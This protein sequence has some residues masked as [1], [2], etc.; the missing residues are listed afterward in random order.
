MPDYYDVTRLDVTAII[1]DVP[2]VWSELPHLTWED[3]NRRRV[4][5]KGYINAPVG[6]ARFALHPDYTLPDGWRLR[7]NGNLLYNP[8]L[9]QTVELRF[10]ATRGSESAYS[11]VLRITRHQAFVS[12][13][14]PDRINIGLEFNNATQRVYVYNTTT[15][16]T[17]D[18]VGHVQDFVTFFDI[19]GNEQVSESLELSLNIPLRASCIG[20][21]GTHIWIGGKD[22]GFYT[23]TGG[24]WKYTT[25][26]TRVAQYTYTNGKLE[27]LAYD[28]TYM[29][30]LDLSNA[31]L[32]AFTLL[33]V[34]QTD[35]TIQLPR[36][37]NDRFHFSDAMYGIG[38]G[39]GHFWIVQSYPDWKIRCVSNAGVLVTS[40]DIVIE[41]GCAGAAYNPTT[42]NLWYIL[43]R[44]NPRRGI[45]RAT[46]I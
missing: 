34:E 40:R 21:D 32:R 12:Q 24:L 30:G 13:L 33:G 11:G 41:P 15:Q 23:G 43:D 45:L 20:F 46:R 25:S 26:G 14:I 22:T 8:V 44:D 16:E 7:S 5:L 3:G 2:I 38:F 18:E 17:V 4:R 10:N 37:G 6:E 35:L 42:R 19:D 28:G 39:D 31:T 36:S 29:W 27:G 9:G 1:E